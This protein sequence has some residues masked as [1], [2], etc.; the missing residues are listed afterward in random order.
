MWAVLAVFVA[1][2]TLN[3][4]GAAAK[5]IRWKVTTTWPASV[6]LIELDKNFL[7]L[8]KELAGD[9][10]KI[11]FHTGGTL[12]PGF[13]L[14]DAVQDGTVDAGFDWPGYWAGKDSAF[15]ILASHPFGL[16][17]TDYINWLFQGGGFDLFQE[18]FGKFGMVYLPHGVTGVESGVR[19]N[20]PIR[21]LAD[22][23]GL[24]IR[25][26]GKIAGMILKEIGA[27]QTLIP[28]AEVYQA[29]Q[30][31]VIDATE[32][33]LPSLDWHLKLGEIT[34]YWCTPGWHA[35]GAVEGLMINKK[36]W[37]ALPDRL[38]AVLKTAAMAN[39]AWSY[40]YFEHESIGGTQK[41]L[42][43]G[44]EVTRLSDK[45]LEE[46]ERV[47]TKVT[48]EMCKQNPL[49]AKVAYSQYKYL[50]DITTWRGYGS[51]FSYGRN[52]KLRPDLEAIKAYIK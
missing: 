46:L 12:I 41:F 10:L 11:Q 3:P 19:S 7:K 20:K 38:K 37:D 35:A 43:K 47:V 25:M 51:P 14:F 27:A 42:D 32:T 50:R 16:T 8:V 13:E 9:E 22:Y 33:F 36:S 39:I 31:G 48:L 17:G 15:S 4:C 21:S 28:G 5:S 18:V 44:I 30:K 6:Q 2:G 26:S 49:F 24:K 52:S 29:M 1:S 40:A 23:K 34:K 45:D